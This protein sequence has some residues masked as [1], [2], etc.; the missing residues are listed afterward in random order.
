MNIRA[1]SQEL[2]MTSR[3]LESEGG[4][5]NAGGPLSQYHAL[6]DSLHGQLLGR[7]DLDVMGSMK[8]EDRKSTRLNS[9]H[10][11]KSR[12]PSSA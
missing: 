4:R 5:S 2:R 9:S 3:L 6:K 7:I 10:I 11:Q 12:M 1:Q 8:P